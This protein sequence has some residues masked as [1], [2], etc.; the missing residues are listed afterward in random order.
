[1]SWS[2]L[3]LS[4]IASSEREAWGVVLALRASLMQSLEPLRRDGSVGG[5]GQ[6]AA[7]VARSE[8]V[9]RALAL[10]HLSEEKLSDVFGTS[11]VVR[12]ELTGAAVLARPA[13]GAKCPRCWQVR[14]DVEPGED[15]ICA[16]CRRVVG[17]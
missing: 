7:V 2:E 3:E 4:E 9:D 12:E 8:D 5:A 11:Y 1:M 6:A 17:G 15:G 10:L 13:E 14:R 16:R